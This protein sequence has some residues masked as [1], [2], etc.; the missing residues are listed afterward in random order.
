MATQLTKN[1]QIVSRHST[2]LGEIRVYARYSS[3]SIESNITYYN[4]KVVYYANLNVNFDSANLNVSCGSKN[5]NYNFGYTSLS[6]G[7][8]TMIEVGWY[9]NHKQD[10][11]LND[12][13]L[14]TNW[15]A[16][17]GGNTGAFSTYIN[18]PRINRYPMITNAPNFNDE[19]NPTITYSTIL[20][21]SNAIVQACISLDRST[22]NVPYRE[23]VVEDGQY[24]FNLTNEERAT[25]RN[26]TPNSNTLN[27]IFI[28]RT[29]VPK[30]GGGYNDYYSTVE[31]QM[32]IVNGNPTFTHSET[33]LNENVVSLVGSGATTVVQNAS[34]LQ[35]TVTPTAVKGASIRNVSVYDEDTYT[36]TITES[37]YVFELP[38]K[39]SSFSIVVRDSRGN[40]ESVRITKTMLPYTP[41]KLNIFTFERENPT[42]SN[43]IVNVEGTYLQT[44]IGST[45][46]V[47]TIKWKLDNGSYATIPSS[48]YSIDTTN[49]KIRITDYVLSNTLVYTSQG[50]FSIELSDLLTSSEETNI[51][52][53]KGIPTFDYGEHDLKVNGDLFVA[54]INGENAVNVLDAINNVLAWQHL[55]DTSGSASINLPSSFNE[56]LCMVKLNNN[57]NIQISIVI[58]YEHLTTTAQGFNGGYLQVYNGNAAMCRISAT[59][60][61]ASLTVAYIQS[62]SVLNNS[63]VSYYYR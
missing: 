46:N 25:L 42:S 15:T 54:D 35:I 37:P 19:E 28:L 52:V 61:T 20:G 5:W 3:Q 36:A 49:N 21:F 50:Y 40:S 27:V 16:S 48:A 6:S 34:T 22:D 18:V 4:I 41:V 53:L 33:D 62:S 39:T 51:L 26:A 59:T 47:P 29:R 11:T 31:K 43:I 63:S 56:L 14:T 30:S 1:Y 12:Q 17:Y 10:G 57:D 60:T 55:G 38:V 32:T 45:A 13:L 23:V 8:N 9:F 2:N 7:E 24:T 58:P 44:T